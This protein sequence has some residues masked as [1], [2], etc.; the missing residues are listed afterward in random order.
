VHARSPVAALLPLLALGLAPATASAVPRIAL[1]PIVVHSSTSEPQYLS[2]GLAEMLSAR[3][4]QSGE[5]AVIRVDSPSGPTTRIDAVLDLARSV[6]ADYVLFG[7]FTQFGQGASLDLRCAALDGDAPG[8]ERRV[9]IQS[10]T[11]AEIIP[12]L[13]ELAEK[14]ARHVKAAAPPPVPA[15][16][17]ASRGPKGSATASVGAPSDGT[18]VR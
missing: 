6:S 18:P 12:K 13:D 3:L 8:A 17:G 11:V 16:A 7:S 10:G 14:V 2:D 1:V 5:I 4:E 9:F 15:A